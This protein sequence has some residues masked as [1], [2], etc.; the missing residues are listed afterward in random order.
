LPLRLRVRGQLQL[1]GPDT[2]T[3]EGGMTGCYLRTLGKRGR[4]TLEISSAQ[5]EPVSIHFTVK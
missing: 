4:A 3:A 5:T 1:V 2:V